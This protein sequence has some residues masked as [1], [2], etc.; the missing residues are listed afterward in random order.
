MR[1][2][3]IPT[4][5]EV[6]EDNEGSDHDTREMA[7]VLVVDDSEANAALVKALLNSQGYECQIAHTGQEALKILEDHD[8]DLISLDIALPDMNGFEVCRHIR[9]ST[10]HRHIPILMVSAHFTDQRNVVEGLEIGAN[11][12]VRVPYAPMEFL[13]RAKGLVRLKTAEARLRALALEDSL[14]HLGNRKMFY[15]RAEAEFSRALR[16]DA[17][18]CLALMDIDNFKEINDKY[19]HLAGDEVLRG[20]GALVHESVRR[21]DVAARWGGDEFALL[22]VNTAMD[23]ALLLMQRILKAVAETDF[24]LD[25]KGIYAK[26]SAGLGQFDPGLHVHVDALVADVDRALFQAKDEGGGRI[27]LVQ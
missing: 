14:T 19:G 26:L 5:A 9:E 12:F 4:P 8:F 18:L 11:D 6:P 25:E 23:G 24:S 17:Q 16:H 15:E 10:L 22:L 27:V 7:S 3:D 21:E 2:A 20:I 1:Y 13:G